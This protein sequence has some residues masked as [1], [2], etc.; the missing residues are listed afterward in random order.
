MHVKSVECKLFRC[1]LFRCDC[2]VSSNL[3]FVRNLFGDI[4]AVKFGDS[5]HRFDFSKAIHDK[6]SSF[7]NATLSIFDLKERSDLCA[8]S[9]LDHFAIFYCPFLIDK[10]L[11]NFYQC[12]MLEIYKG[13][14]LKFLKFSTYV[15]EIFKTNLSLQMLPIFIKQFQSHLCPLRAHI[16]EICDI[17]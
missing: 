3:K 15:D 17:T 6:L 7:W 1:I 11:V 9:N 14:A 16:Y 10:F 12:L 4:F 13:T 5:F 8:V 2:L